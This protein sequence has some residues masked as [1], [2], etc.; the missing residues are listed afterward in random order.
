M[1]SKT[2]STEMKSDT[3]GPPLL[4]A[5]FG[6]CSQL[7]TLGYVW[8][9]HTSAGEAMRA[10]LAALRS[11]GTADTWGLTVVGFVPYVIAQWALSLRSIPKTG[12]SDPSIVDRLWSV[13]PWLYVWG[14]YLKSDAVAKKSSNR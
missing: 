13:M 14:W 5:L 12:T 7:G 3:K 10:P 2:G 8:S 11:P 1:T 6:A 9:Q 4:A